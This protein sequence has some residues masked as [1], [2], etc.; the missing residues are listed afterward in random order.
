MTAYTHIILL[1]SISQSVVE[2]KL[3]VP[4]IPLGGPQI[5][6]LVIMFLKP[7]CFFFHFHSLMSL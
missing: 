6:P 2:G 3:A 5:K 4:V 7:D 1:F